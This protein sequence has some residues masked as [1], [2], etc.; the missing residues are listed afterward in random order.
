MRITSLL[1]NK[2]MSRAELIEAT[3]L[4]ERRITRELDDMRLLEIVDFQKFSSG[5]AGA[6]LMKLRVKPDI[7]DTLSTLEIG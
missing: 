1:A 7:A 2:W 3:Q 5:Y 6:K 4:P